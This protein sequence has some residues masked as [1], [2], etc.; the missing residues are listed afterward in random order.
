MTG[1]RSGR[2]R[3]YTLAV[4]DQ[5]VWGPQYGSYSRSDAHEEMLDHAERYALKDLKIIRTDD[6]QA[7]IDAAIAKLNAGRGAA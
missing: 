7:A 3:Y 6:E 1:N 5:G 2:R 4:R